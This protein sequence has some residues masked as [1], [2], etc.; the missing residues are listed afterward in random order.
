[1]SYTVPAAVMQQQMLPECEYLSHSTAS[2]LDYA[3]MIDVSPTS[4][5]IEEGRAWLATASER[6]E[7]N[8]ARA[9]VLHAYEINALTAKAAIYALIENEAF[10]FDLVCGM[11]VIHAR[12]CAIIEG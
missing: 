3:E 7:A 2:I 11:L 1:M 6:F 10:D 12:T 4:E 5:E 8:M 9:A